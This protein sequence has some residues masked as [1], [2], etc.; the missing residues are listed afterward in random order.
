MAK[1]PSFGVDSFH[2]D[3]ENLMSSLD[4][5]SS[6]AFAPDELRSS[7]EFVQHDSQLHEQS[8]IDAEMLP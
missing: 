6:I 2:N 3:P 1:Q 4:H 8:S 7:S 5:Q